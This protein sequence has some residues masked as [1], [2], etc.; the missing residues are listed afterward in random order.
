MDTSPD[1]TTPVEIPLPEDHFRRMGVASRPTFFRWE[2]QGLRVLRI[3]GRRFIFASDLKAFLERKDQEAKAG[4]S[5]P[6]QPK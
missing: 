3:G 6:V 5:T 4:R 1:T 2:R